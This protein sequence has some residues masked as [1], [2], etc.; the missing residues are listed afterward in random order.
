MQ[1][2]GTFSSV[3]D[4]SRGNLTSYIT[5]L[6]AHQGSIMILT[7]DKYSAFVNCLKKRQGKEKQSAMPSLLIQSEQP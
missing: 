2:F 5:L 1:I 4:S 7:N 6:M 3:L